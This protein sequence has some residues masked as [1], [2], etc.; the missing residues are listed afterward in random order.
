MPKIIHEDDEGNVILSVV[1]KEHKDRAFQQFINL[2][3][4]R[5]E[6]TRRP[7]EQNTTTVKTDADMFKC[8]E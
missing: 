3:I 4:H 5:K 1:Y 2:T 8:F 7:K 6:Y